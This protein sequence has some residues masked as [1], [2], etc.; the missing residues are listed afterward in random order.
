MSNNA[1]WSVSADCVMPYQ[2]C[3]FCKPVKITNGTVGE[4]LQGTDINLAAISKLQ[5]KQKRPLS[6]SWTRYT[7]ERHGT[8]D[9]RTR[10]LHPID[11]GGANG[12][13]S[14]YC[15]RRTEARRQVRVRSAPLPVC[16]C[17]TRLR[18][19]VPVRNGHRPC[20]MLPAVSAA[21][22]A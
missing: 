3:T 9:F 10:L 2:N 22:L 18:Y 4:Q 16:K 7:L 8:Q 14:S 19:S 5:G 15:P 13:D 1:C 21:A 12:C 6:Y 17:C 20:Q 11:C